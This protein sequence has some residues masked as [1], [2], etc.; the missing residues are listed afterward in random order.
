MMKKF[1]LRLFLFFTILFAGSYA[2][3]FAM[4]ATLKKSNSY[5]MGEFA[6]WNDVL[7]GTLNAEVI[8]NGSSRAWVQFDPTMIQDSLGHSCYNI[9]IDGHAFH[10]QYLRH[11]LMLKNHPKPK[12]II[13]SVDVWSLQK[14]PELYNQ[15]QFLPYMLWNTTMA[16]YISQYQGYSLADY[17]LPLVRYYGNK[18]A[19]E[20]TCEIWL[21]KEPNAIKRIKGY[22]PQYKTWNSDLEKA[23]KNMKFFEPK[24]DTLTL[25][26]FNQYLEECKKENI[27]VILVHAPEYIEG[28]KFT[29]NRTETLSIFVELSRKHNISYLDFSADSISS[30]RDLFYNA[31]H[32]N[33]E[34]A[35]LF[36]KKLIQELKR[37]DSLKRMRN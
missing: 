28:Q 27:E 30:N 26:L 31:M 20:K 19:F 7:N 24:I 14:R 34:G 9:G 18:D 22:E 5:A 33:N 29:R 21:G 32:L 3:D 36:T 1:L 6:T 10:L 37:T 4:S 12:V 2:L 11:L 8:I 23:K 16:Q 17:M 35:Q 13:Q 25:R 15:E